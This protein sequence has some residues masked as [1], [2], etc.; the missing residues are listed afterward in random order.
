MEQ[1]QQAL[2]AGLLPLALARQKHLV[3]LLVAAVFQRLE[4][5]V[6]RVA[7]LVVH[8]VLEAQVQLL[9]QHLEPVVVVVA[10]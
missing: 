6:V 7:L 3:A 9:E 4:R 8:W 10:V 2:L 1:A 5:L